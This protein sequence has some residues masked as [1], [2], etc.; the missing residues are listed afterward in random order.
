MKKLNTMFLLAVPVCAINMQVNEILTQP[1]VEI[2]DQTVSATVIPTTTPTIERNEIVE[3]EMAVPEESS[4]VVEEEDLEE[5]I[6]L[7]DYMG[8]LELLAAI[9]EAEA[10]NQ[11]L[12]G[13]RLVAD[14]VLNRVESDRFPG[15]ITDVIYQKYQFSSVWDG[16]LD[17]AYWNISDDSFTAVRIE[18][19]ESDE[20]LDN[21][22]LF[23][24]AGDYNPYCIP[25]Y[26]HEAHYFGY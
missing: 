7:E 21:E 24:T 13:K 23:F 9:V 8:E 14:V 16:S 17:K 12:K 20:R 26:R 4:E 15:T 11:D 18:A 6:E 22:I 19:L 25:G 1:T 3:T 2:P 10:G 5:Q